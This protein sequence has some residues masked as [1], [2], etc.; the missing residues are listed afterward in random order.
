MRNLNIV[1]SSLFL[2][3]TAFGFS[4]SAHAEK[5]LLKVKVNKVPAST[6][7][8]AQIFLS[9]FKSAD[10]FPDDE[11]LMYQKVTVTPVQGSTIVP[12]SLE[13]GVYAITLFHDVDGDGKMNTKGF[14]IPAEPFGFSNDPTIYFGAPSFKECAFRVP[15]RASE[16]VINL[17]TF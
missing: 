9:V 16:I 2:M 10:G 5:V 6:D 7:P 4:Q 8:D 14:G 11:D 15:N 12:V 13:P 17:K 3:V 1:L